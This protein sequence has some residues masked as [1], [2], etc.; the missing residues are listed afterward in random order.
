[1]SKEKKETELLSKVQT[2]YLLRTTLIT[3]VTL[4]KISKH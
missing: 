1:M 2:V 3:Q 4:L